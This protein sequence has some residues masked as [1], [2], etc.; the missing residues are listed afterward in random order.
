MARSFIFGLIL[1]LFIPTLGIYVL[2][3]K[4]INDCHQTINDIDVKKKRAEDERDNV[5]KENLKWENL[6]KEIFR[7]KKKKEKENE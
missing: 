2:Y 5:K 6:S 3:N 1:G 7:L 4:N